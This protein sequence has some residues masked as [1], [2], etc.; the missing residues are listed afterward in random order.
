MK[1][2]VLDQKMRKKEMK[3]KSNKMKIRNNKEIMQ[4]KY[5]TSNSNSK[6]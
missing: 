1:Y 4:I 6:K 3:I 5:N 2:S